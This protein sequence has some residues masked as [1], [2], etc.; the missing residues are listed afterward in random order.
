ME[1]RIINAK[2]FKT[3]RWSGGTTTELFIFPQDSNFQNRDFT[4]RLSTA[5]V[6]AAASEFT[7]LPGVSR[8]LLVLDGEITLLH[9]DQHTAHLKEFDVDHFKGDWK[10]TCIG[11]CTDF[12]LM[13]RGEISG[14]VRGFVLESEQQ[15]KI[16]IDDHTDWCFIYMYSGSAVI[17]IND[18]PISLCL[19]DLLVMEKCNGTAFAIKGIERSELVSCTLDE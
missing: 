2:D 10:T 4:F 16:E 13:T 3:N 11:T 5:T 17:T 9:A 14:V 19:G 6:E 8:T 12:N 1:N 15:D 18:N 7:M